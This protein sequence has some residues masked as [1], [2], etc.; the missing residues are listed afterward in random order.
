MVPAADRAAAVSAAASR[1]DGTREAQVPAPEAEPRQAAAAITTISTTKSRSDGQNL[2]RGRAQLSVTNFCHTARR[3][4]DKC[5]Q[6]EC[7]YAG[8]LVGLLSGP[9]SR[10]ICFSAGDR[11]DGHGHRRRYA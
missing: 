6:A 7:I 9:Y 11:R 4:R 10:C 3:A 5:A 8:A 2:A 1:A